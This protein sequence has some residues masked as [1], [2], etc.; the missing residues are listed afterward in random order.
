MSSSDDA[1]S[2]PKDATSALPPLYPE[3]LLDVVQALGGLTSESAAQREF[4]LKIQKLYFEDLPT[5]YAGDECASGYLREVLAATASA[6]RGFAVER[7]AFRAVRA[8]EE[9]LEELRS[10]V[11]NAKFF[12]APVG[13]ELGT[14]FYAI[15][16]KLV[17]GTIGGATLVKAWSALPLWAVAVIAALTFMWLFFGDLLFALVT[18]RLQLSAYRTTGDT[19]EEIRKA[20]SKSQDSY[21]ELAFQLLVATDRARERWYPN[22]VGLL[23]R[24]QWSDGFERGARAFLDTPSSKL[25]GAIPAAAISQIVDMH[26]GVRSPLRLYRTTVTAN[27]TPEPPEATNA[28]DQQLGM[29][30]TAETAKK[31]VESHAESGE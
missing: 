30:S 15:A 4:A 31:D 26:F 27:K 1:H 3:A 19:E 8:R 20:W 12:H 24:L 14:K 16:V 23:G 25:A 2:G 6:I 10:R 21:K 5:K 7:T 29:P 28:G 13:G 22:T 9:K 18:V 17:G 11:T